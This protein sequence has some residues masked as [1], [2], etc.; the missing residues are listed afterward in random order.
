MLSLKELPFLIV[1][2]TMGMLS[3]SKNFMP[4]LPNFSVSE[5]A[6]GKVTVEVFVAE[7]AFI[8]LSLGRDKERKE[9]M[10]KLK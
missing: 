1:S 6:V 9:A 8:R 7:E 5:S 10:E 2:S 4:F 3:D